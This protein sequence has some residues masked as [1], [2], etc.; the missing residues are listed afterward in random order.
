MFYWCCRVCC[1]LGIFWGG[2]VYKN[3]CVDGEC[4][5]NFVVIGIIGWGGMGV[6]FVVGGDVYFICCIGCYCFFWVIV[7]NVGDCY[8]VGWNVVI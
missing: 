4:G 1:D 7:C 2:G 8:V 3:Y 6:C 5:V